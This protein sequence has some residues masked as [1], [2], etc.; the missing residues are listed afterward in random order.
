[1]GEFGLG[2]AY[3]GTIGIQGGILSRRL[4]ILSSDPIIHVHGTKR[5]S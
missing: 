4:F 2:L 5:E 1:M 3:A